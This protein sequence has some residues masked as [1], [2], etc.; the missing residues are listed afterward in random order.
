MPRKLQKTIVETAKYLAEKVSESSAEVDF[1]YG[2]HSVMPYGFDELN[3]KINDAY[4][5]L[6]KEYDF[7]LDFR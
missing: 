6:C 1:I 3:E 7:I 2:S 5:S 4:S